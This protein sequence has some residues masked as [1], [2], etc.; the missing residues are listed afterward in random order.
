MPHVAGGMNKQRARPSVFDQALVKKIDTGS[1]TL[2]NNRQET[3]HT[4][5][6][7]NNGPFLINTNNFTKTKNTKQ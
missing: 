6:W 1:K 4:R 3:A 2:V 7:S 5:S